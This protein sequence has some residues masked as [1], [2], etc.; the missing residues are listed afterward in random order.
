MT[1][2]GTSGRLIPS[3]E[4]AGALPS[5]RLGRP[6]W[7]DWRATLT[8]LPGGRAAGPRTQ[9]LWPHLLPPQAGWSRASAAWSDSLGQGPVC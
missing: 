5:R 4:K 3:A 1:W 7:K 8:F 6:G 2:P 9:S